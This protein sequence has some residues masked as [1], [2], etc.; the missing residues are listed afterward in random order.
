MNFKEPVKSSY[1]DAKLMIN[2]I[3][4]H[5]S[6]IF[7]FFALIGSCS[8]GFTFVYNHFAKTDDLLTTICERQ[9]TDRDIELQIER[10]KNEAMIEYANSILNMFEEID[11]NQDNPATLIWT[12]QFRDLKEEHERKLKLLNRVPSYYTPSVISK[13][14]SSSPPVVEPHNSFSLMFDSWEG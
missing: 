12:K 13:C 4:K 8:A 11:E 9:A 7:G 2:L 1:E 5:K 10:S 3:I 6:W 14:K